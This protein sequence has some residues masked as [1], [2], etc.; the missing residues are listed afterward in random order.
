MKTR[1]PYLDEAVAIL[2]GG[3]RAGQPGM[4]LR[5]GRR[6]ISEHGP[7]GPVSP[8]AQKLS[9]VAMRMMRSVGEAGDLLPVIGS[10]VVGVVD[11]D[12]QALRRRGRIPW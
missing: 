10:L 3:C 12:Q 8:M 7:Q 4:P 6:N 2:V 9:L 1:I 5:R 11:G